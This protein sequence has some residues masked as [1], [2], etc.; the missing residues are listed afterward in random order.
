MTDDTDHPAP[1]P[2]YTSNS[3]ILRIESEL[4][5]GD[6]PAM[7]LSAHP[8]F[9]DTP[10]TVNEIRAEIEAEATSDDPDQRRIAALNRQLSALQDTD[11]ATDTEAGP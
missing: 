5:E 3:E 2:R 1:G 7:P 4:G 8:E 6:N 11:S 10:D 9:G